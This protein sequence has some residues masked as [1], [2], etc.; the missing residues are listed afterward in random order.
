M[1]ALSLSPT[2][3]SHMLSHHMIPNLGRA[4]R[5]G[6]D[7]IV[8]NELEMLACVYVCVCVLGGGGRARGT[9]ISAATM[10]DECD[11]DLPNV[12]DDN[13]TLK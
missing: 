12:V 6:E 4:T 1:Q 10:A 8:A 7:V 9:E 11:H 13:I 5:P 2:L 3:L